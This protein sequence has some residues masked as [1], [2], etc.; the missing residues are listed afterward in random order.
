MLTDIA[1]GVYQDP[2]NPAPPPD[3]P[4]LGQ[5]A[6][7]WV[8]S[9]AA[10]DRTRAG[11]VGQLRNHLLP[12]FA[13]T[14]LDDINWWLVST[15]ASKQACAPRSTRLRI[16]L[17]SQILTAAVDADLID[18]NKIYGRRLGGTPQR[19]REKIWPTTTEAIA[20]AERLGRRA[21]DYQAP[22]GRYQPAAK[23]AG[24]SPTLDRVLRLLTYV[25]YFTGMRSGEAYGLSIGNTNLWRR[26]LIDGKPWRRRVIRIDPQVGQLG[27]YYDYDLGCTVRNLMPPKPPNGDRE[28]DL[29]LFLSTMLEEHLADWPHPQTFCNPDGSWLTTSQVDH[30]MAKAA[31][32]RPARAAMHAFGV[33]WPALEAQEPILPGLGPHGFRHGHQTAMVEDGIAHVM[34]CDRMGHSKER[35]D[36]YAAETSAIQG[37]YS[38]ATLVMRRQVVDTQQARYE[39]ALAQ[40][41]RSA[42]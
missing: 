24:V 17:L 25:F 41:D 40:Y 28:L 15:W 22:D 29:P 26:D 31:A 35:A 16:S 30:A 11:R 10:S 19:R 12:A 38:H 5:W 42:A 36:G 14:A 32:G 9:A 34:R 21:E 20:V 23:H 33:D 4:T 2:N 13:D 7:K 3:R 39:A 1:R 37:R 18:T 8:V 6:P 27:A